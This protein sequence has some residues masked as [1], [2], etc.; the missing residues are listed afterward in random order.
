MQSII[1]A[2]TD[3]LK[4]LF[5]PKEALPSDASDLKPDSVIITTPVEIVEIKPVETKKKHKPK[6]CWC[7][8]NGHGKKTVGKRSPKL[9]TTGI[10]LEEWKWNREI[11]ERIAEKLKEY[12]VEYFIVVPEED[13]DNFVSGRIKRANNHVSELPK[14]FLS[15]HSN[16]APA[17]T[18]KWCE[19]KISGIET[20]FYHGSDEGEKIA[21]IFQ[22][23]LIA[24]TGWKNRFLKSRPDNQ[25]RVLKETHMTAVLT[26]NGFYNNKAQ[27]IELLKEETKDKIAAAH[28]DAIMEIELEW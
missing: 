5:A 22:K 17:P 16:A 21:A 3:F 10:R 9:E 15:I 11:V 6:Y 19:E 23:H 14:L 25:F 4:R 18:G 2:I 7:I 28:V 26:E 24:A 13:V 8:D 1:K 20:W 27:C 12:G